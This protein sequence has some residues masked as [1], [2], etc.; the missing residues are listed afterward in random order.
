MKQYGSSF[1]LLSLAFV[2]GASI[3][4]MQL[5]A[6]SLLSPYFGSTL[7]AWAVLIAIMFA[8]FALGYACGAIARAIRVSYLLA[9]SATYII[10]AAGFSS[11][12]SRLIDFGVLAG[13]AVA[14]LLLLFV[15]VALLSI[16][17]IVVTEQL[18]TGGRMGAGLNNGLTFFISTAGG[19]ASAFFT[20]FY[21]IP[22]FGP[23]TMLLTLGLFLFVIALPAMLL[24]SRAAGK[25]LAFGLLG[26]VVTS[27]LLT[28]NEPELPGK[29]IKQLSYG[30]LGQLI[31][32]DDTTEQKRIMYI[33]GSAQAQVTLPEYTSVY[34]YVQ[35]LINKT[36]TLGQH[37]SVLILGMGSGYL[38]SHYAARGASVD[39]V[40]LDA[41]IPEAAANYFTRDGKQASVHIDDARHFLNTVAGLRQYDLIVVD[42]YTGDNAPFHVITRE[43]FSKMKQLLKENGLLCVYFPYSLD[44]KMLAAHAILR[45]TLLAAGFECAENDAG[46]GRLLVYAYPVRKEAGASD[47]SIF[48]DNKPQLELLLRHQHEVLNSLRKRLWQRK[49]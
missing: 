49:S 47:E 30:M 27:L 45:N 32:A 3:M 23:Q 17:P 33:N 36:D 1:V 19:I 21:F 4:C 8:A 48:T 22:A 35:E 29:E 37:S 25:A 16:I 12:A 5:C 13:M 18:R 14:A 11:Q 24:R 31:V 2:E 7:Q 42:V 15:P 41:R 43:A 20:G 40:E 9:L 28:N 26:A 46:P 44:E 39:L 10:L 34:G 38:A 6:G